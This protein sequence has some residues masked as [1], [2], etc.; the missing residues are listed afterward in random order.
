MV[1]TLEQMPIRYPSFI[2]TDSG[3]IQEFELSYVNDWTKED[4]LIVYV[5]L[6]SHNDPGPN[7]VLMILIPLTESHYWSYIIS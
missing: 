4:P 5:V 1:D 7:F 6:H 3:W 2:W